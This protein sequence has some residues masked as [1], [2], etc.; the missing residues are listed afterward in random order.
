MADAWR[1]RGIV[2]MLLER[3]ATRARAAGIEQF[4]A[5]CLASNHT[6]IRL[7]SG[8]GPTTVGPSDAGVV[9]LRIDLKSPVPIAALRSRR[10]AGGAIEGRSCDG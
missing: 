1:G 10:A 5:I 2:S 7:L 8:L 6:V 4:I 9:E 3:V